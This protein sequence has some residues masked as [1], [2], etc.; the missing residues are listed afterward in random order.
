MSIFYEIEF[1]KYILPYHGEP[2]ERRPR[3][4]QRCR[5]R[6]LDDGAGCGVG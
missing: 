5:H 3:T 1:A 6:S 2:D 4:D